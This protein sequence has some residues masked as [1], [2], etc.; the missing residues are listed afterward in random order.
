MET[1]TSA[2]GFDGAEVDAEAV[3]EHE[4]LAGGEVRRDLGFVE[5]ALDVIGNQDHH[6][7]G[8]FGGFGGVEHGETGGLRFGAA[9]AVGRETDH[10]V[11]AGIAQVEGVSVALAAIA[12]D[13]DLFAFKR[14]STL[15][16]FS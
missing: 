1:S 16:S 4:G 9:L 15:P 7:V 11:E 6:D 10:N 5:G 14:G 8:H 2:G 13:G 12:N 3:G